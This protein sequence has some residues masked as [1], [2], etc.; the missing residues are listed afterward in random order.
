MLIILSED[1]QQVNRKLGKRVSTS[2]NRFHNFFTGLHVFPTPNY[3]IDCQQ[4]QCPKPKSAHSLAQNMSADHQCI[5][6]KAQ[7]PWNGL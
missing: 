7:L 4:R 6:N 5:Q 1:S 3:P 2:D